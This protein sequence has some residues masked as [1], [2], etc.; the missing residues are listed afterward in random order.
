MI[1][2]LL[3]ILLCKLKAPLFLYTILSG[4]FDNTDPLIPDLLELGF[5][6]KNVKQIAQ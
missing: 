1:A 4:L 5:Q 6:V 3:F 2:L